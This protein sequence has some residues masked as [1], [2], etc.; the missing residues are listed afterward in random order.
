MCV[1]V[2]VL[3][4]QTTG[5]WRAVR[6]M[7]GVLYPPENGWGDLVYVAVSLKPEAEEAAGGGLCS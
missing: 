7:D 3:R 2:C 5:A 6:V 1:C 4:N